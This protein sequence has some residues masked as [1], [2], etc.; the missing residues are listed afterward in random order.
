MFP[1]KCPMHYEGCGGEITS[2]VSKRVLA[3]VQYDRFLEFHDRATYGDGMRCIFCNNFVNFPL[4]QNSITMV[5]CPYCVQKFCIRCK[6]PWHYGGKCPL[7]KM[8]DGL[9][10]WKSESGA[11]SCPAC[12]KIIEKDDPETC[13]HMV[14]KL[15]D[16]IPC[17]RDRTD[18]CYLC[19]TEVAGDYPH[20]EIDNPT[21][22]HFPDGVFQKCRKAMKKEKDAERERLRKERRNTR[23]LTN[24]QASS[25]RASPNT[26]DL[27][28]DDKTV[29]TVSGASSMDRLWSTAEGESSPLGSP[30]QNMRS[31][32]EFRRGS[33]TRG[34][35]SS[36]GASPGTV[37]PYR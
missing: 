9:S 33:P 26:P 12:R 24:I 15:T 2:F 23:R 11:S 25:T 7:D 34:R 17:I 35:T 16:S 1:V 5:E 6:K 18:F 31:S 19:G 27:V 29:A 28:W 36:A 14:H 13:H 20:V 37:V 4:Q 3:K 8:D 30:I 22:N 10:M 21:V 32:P